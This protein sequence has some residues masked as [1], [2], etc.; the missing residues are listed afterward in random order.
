MEDI[1]MLKLV[2]TALNHVLSVVPR[3]LD[4]LL[5]VDQESLQMI[6]VHDPILGV[7]VEEVLDLFG[8]FAGGHPE[9]PAEAEAHS[10]GLLR[11]GGEELEGYGGI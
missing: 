10:V 5:N 11:H 7:L 2:S 9:T 8:G 4:L 3:R 6:S 1:Q